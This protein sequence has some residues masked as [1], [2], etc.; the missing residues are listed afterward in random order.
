[1]QTTRT[2]YTPNRHS[3]LDSFSPL[4]LRIVLL[5]I[6]ILSLGW[7]LMYA[8]LPRAAMQSTAPVRNQMPNDTASPPSS[9]SSISRQTAVQNTAPSPPSGQS[10]SVEVNGQQVAVPSNGQIHTVINSDGQT[11]HVDIANTSQG[12]HNT[13][14]ISIHS[15]SGTEAAND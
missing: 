12:A 3:L 7:L 6:A 8:Y 4:F 10:T 5:A 11:T 1:M 2:A 15:S 9:A 14:N 13:S